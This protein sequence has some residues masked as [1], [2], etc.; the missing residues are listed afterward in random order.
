MAA[1]VAGYLSRGPS[2][3]DQFEYGVLIK[4]AIPVSLFFIAVAVLMHI[5]ILFAKSLISDNHKI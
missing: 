4:F 3:D 1:L 2:I 5:D